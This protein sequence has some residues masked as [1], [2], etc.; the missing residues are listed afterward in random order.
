MSNSIH[1]TLIDIRKQYLSKANPQKKKP[2]KK[3]CNIF[4]EEKENLNNSFFRTAQFYEVWGKKNTMFK[5][6]AF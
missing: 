1:S 6:S 3:S 4:R 2:S 5:E